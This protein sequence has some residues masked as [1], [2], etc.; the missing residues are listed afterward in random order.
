M[1]P[2]RK[3]RNWIDGKVA[4]ANLDW[5]GSPWRT[6]TTG[7]DDT[8]DSPQP[9][10]SAPDVSLDCIRRA[11]PEKPASQRGG[12]SP[13]LPRREFSQGKTP[14]QQGNLEILKPLAP[15]PRWPWR[16]RASGPA[17][18]TADRTTCEQQAPRNRWDTH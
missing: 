6:P 2:W 16:N 17:A 9:A 12:R 1:I 5:G 3:W 18:Q 15:S 14:G 13:G 8:S 10:A 4:T 7:P 11:E